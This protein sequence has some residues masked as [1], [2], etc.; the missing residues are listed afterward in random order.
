MINGEKLENVFVSNNTMRIMWSYRP[1]AKNLDKN[2][3][4][5]F[6]FRK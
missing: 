6:L 5:E 1:F 4:T 2:T 3:R